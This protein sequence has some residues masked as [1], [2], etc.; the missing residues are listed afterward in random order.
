MPHR[1]TPV[2]RALQPRVVEHDH[3]AILCLLH[4][5]LHHVGAGAPR[6][7]D[8]GAG[9]LR[10]HGRRAAVPDHQAPARNPGR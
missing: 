8:R 9:V 4:I 10:R 6:R 5:E 1:P 7:E 3:P 2:G